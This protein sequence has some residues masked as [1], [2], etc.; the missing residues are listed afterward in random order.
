[1]ESRSAAKGGAHLGDV[2]G[3]IVD[4]VHVHVVGLLLED[5]LEGL[6]HEEGH[7]RAVHPRKIGRAR[8]ASQIILP[9]LCTPTPTAVS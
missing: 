7:G 4:D 9:F 5:L 8:H 3:D 6:P 1:M 2:V